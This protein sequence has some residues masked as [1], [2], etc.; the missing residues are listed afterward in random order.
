MFDVGISTQGDTKTMLLCS[1]AGKL[2]QHFIKLT[3]GDK[4]P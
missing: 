2:K 3:V 4:V 1:L